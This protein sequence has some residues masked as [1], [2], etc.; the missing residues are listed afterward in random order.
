MSKGKYIQQ[1]W[2]YRITFGGGDKRVG[3]HLRKFQNSKKG[4]YL[5]YLINR[6]IRE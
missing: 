3:G 5:C 2:T 6:K 4:L 1:I